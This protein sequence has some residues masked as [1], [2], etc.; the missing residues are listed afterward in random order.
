M[1]SVSSPDEWKNVGA[2]ATLVDG[3]A[4]ANKGDNR[5]LQ[6]EKSRGQISI[7]T[8]SSRRQPLSVRRRLN[9]KM[10]KVFGKSCSKDVE[11][12]PCAKD[13]MQIKGGQV[14]QIHRRFSLMLARRELMQQEAQQTKTKLHERPS[15]LP[16]MAAAAKVAGVRNDLAEPRPLLL[17]LLPRPQRS[18]AMLGSDCLDC[19]AG[20]KVYLAD[21]ISSVCAKFGKSS[22]DDSAGTKE[23]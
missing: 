8:S 12:T 14:I 6:R 4:R 19:A 23:H 9:R 21:V 5:K 1:A 3:P 16:L 13:G 7:G 20:I 10:R 15:L 17:P 2:L 11:R 22:S 18:S